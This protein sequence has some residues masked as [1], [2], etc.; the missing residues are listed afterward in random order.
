MPLM[1]L[2]N[3]II[4]ELFY[5]PQISKEEL[6]FSRGHK[7]NKNLE[8]SSFS[9]PTSPGKSLD[10]LTIGSLQS[11]GAKT[12]RT[13]KKLRRNWISK[14][15]ITLYLMTIFGAL[16]RN[17]FRRPRLVAISVASQPSPSQLIFAGFCLSWQSHNTVSCLTVGV[18]CQGEVDLAHEASRISA[19][20]NRK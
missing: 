8:F 12:S 11:S 16:R 17:F 19:V 3:L 18:F 20:R 4:Y 1:K 9:K 6:R 15:K 7:K 10:P 14:L 13:C 2:N 5:M